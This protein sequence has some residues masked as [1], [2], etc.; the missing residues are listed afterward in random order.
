M[1]TAPS[2][3]GRILDALRTHHGKV[4]PPPA[5]NAF[6]LVVWEKAAYLAT[7]ERRAAAFALLRKRIGLSPRAILKANRGT[8]VD[9]LATGGI[10]AAERA[11]NL[12]A[13]AELTVGDFDGS[14]D[15][16]CSRP[17]N[18]A[19]KQLKRVRGIGDPG[20]EKILLLTRAHAVLGLDS[21]AM[22]VL[23]RLGYG[24]PSKTYGTTY[25][26]VTAAALPELGDDVDRLIEAH[27]LLRRHGQTICKTSEPRCGACVLNKSC[28]SARRDV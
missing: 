5:Q 3:L 26:S 25:K 27:L 7:D 14:L 28:P 13:A 18:E 22:R 8:L 15:D 2:P 20:A 10:A 12:I 11:N 9:V 17:L 6:E 19:K 1:Q 21:N 24:T 16:V 23:L 4:S